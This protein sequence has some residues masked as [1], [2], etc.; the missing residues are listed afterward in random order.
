LQTLRKP[1]AGSPMLALVGAFSLAAVHQ[2]LFFGHDPGASFPLFISLLYAYLFHDR[3]GRIGRMSGFGWFML[4][5]VLL[6]S[7]T[8]VWF[9]NPVF[10]GL[11]ALVVPALVCLHLA[12]ERG[13]EKTE[14]WDI[15]IVGVALKHLIPLSLRHAPTAFRL[16]RVA[17]MRRVGRKQK[18]AAG[19]VLTGLALAVLV[20]LV[21]VPLLASADGAF[22]RLL[23]GLPELAREL[24]L[25]E[26]LGRAIWI[27]VLCAL[28][29][30]YSQGF[31]KPE[32]RKRPPRAAGSAGPEADAGERAAE[33][34]RGR[35]AVIDP[36]V[37]ATLLTAVNAVYVLFVAVQ[38]KY[39]F[40][41]RD[42]ILPDGQTYAEYA[43][44]GFGELVAVTAINFALLMVALVYGGKLRKLVSALLYVLILCSGVMLFSAYSRLAMY[45]QAYGYTYIRFLVH[46]FMIYLAVLLVVAALRVR[47]SLVPLSKCYIAISL[48]AYVFVN[49]VGMDRMI[50]EQNLA[51]YER[52]GDIDRWYLSR[53]SADAVPTLVRFGKEEGDEELRALLRSRSGSA[54]EDHD[55]RSYNLAVH[56]ADRALRHWDREVARR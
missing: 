24:S 34:R 28:L 16:A 17:S 48:A 47:T 23:N 38:F 30:G 6:L 2:Y 1:T 19:K 32:R 54:Y 31:A 39:L 29:F 44:S 3:K 11:N 50:A 7:L 40:G 56:R 43:R 55:W 37:L 14:W 35:K 15:R 25:G 52:T 8:Y 41:A 10:Y 9:H 33:I 4:A 51:R 45:E 22:N 13:A 5:V 26:L 46:A 12:Y 21:V 18:S 53:L 49:Y 27:A 20:L 42:G 36:V